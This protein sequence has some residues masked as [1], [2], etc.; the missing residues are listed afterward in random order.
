MNRP[1]SHHRTHRLG[2]SHPILKC[3]IGRNPVHNPY[4]FRIANTPLITSE[5]TPPTDKLVSV[6]NIRKTCP[7]LH[8]ALGGG[9]ELV[10]YLADHQ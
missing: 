4:V 6:R 7:P 3:N 1:I 2:Y 8:K 9:G 10:T 5:K